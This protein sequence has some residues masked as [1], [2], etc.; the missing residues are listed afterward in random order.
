MKLNLCKIVDGCRLGTLTNLGKKEVQSMEI[1]GCLLYTKMGTAPHLTHDTLHS[2]QGLPVVVQISL[3]TLADLQEVLQEYKEGIGKFIGMPESILYCSLQDPA[4][5]SPHGYNS[6][7]TVSIWNNR[8]RKELTASKFMDIQKAIQ[9]DWFQCLSDGDTISA[10][11]SRKKAKKSVDRSLYF[12]DECLQLQ[13]NS[14]E[15]KQSLMFGVIEGGDVLEERLRSARETAKRPVAGFLLDAF[16]GNTMTKETKLELLT[17]V[18]AELPEDKPRLIHGIGKPD[19][20]LECIKRGIDIFDSSFPYQVTE[21]HC[22]L[23][24]SYDYQ[25]NPESADIE[26]D[27]KTEVRKDDKKPKDETCSEAQEKD[28]ENPKDE[29]CREA[30]EMTSFEIHLKD[31]KYQDDFNPLVNGCS[32]YCC[33]NHSRAYVHHLVMTKELLAYV[34]LMMHNFQ[35]YFGFFS[36]IRNALKEDKLDQLRKVISRQAL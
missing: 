14:P 13:E 30:Q 33:Q 35:H 3:T 24:F 9:P 28:D 34:L 8:G 7:K 12:L 27:E 6:M 32:C 31:R 25:L 15:L 29:T 5:C 22:A 23:C 11:I 21:R 17:S 18:I 10:D 4:V 20:I 16:Q 36:S 2:I 26:E 1:P 19:E